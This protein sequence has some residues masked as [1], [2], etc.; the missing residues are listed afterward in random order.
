MDARAF[1][2]AGWGVDRMSE[3][4]ERAAK[5]LFDE[6]VTRDSTHPPMG[7]ERLAICRQAVCIVLEVMREPTKQMVQAGWGRAQFADSLMTDDGERENVAEI[8]EAMIAEAL[9]A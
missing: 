3:M 8:F 5:A 2:R 1:G 7:P 6:G 4:I 9:E